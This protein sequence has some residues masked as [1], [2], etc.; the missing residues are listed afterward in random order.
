MSKCLPGMP[1]WSTTYQNGLV[2][3]TTYPQG[4]SPCSQDVLLS[5]DKIYYAG[6]NLP[7]TGIQ[8]EDT[9]SDAIEKIDGKLAPE[10]IFNAF[11]VAIENNPSLKTIFCE[12]FNE[13]P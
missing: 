2:V 12:K 6:A 13:C 3:Y 9:I 11:I 1:C 4:C 8:T 10:E 7:Y 5:S